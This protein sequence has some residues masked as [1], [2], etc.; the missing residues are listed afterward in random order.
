MG[1]GVKNVA[2]E[3]ILASLDLVHG[4]PLITDSILSY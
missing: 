2:S 3:Q 4:L 1:G